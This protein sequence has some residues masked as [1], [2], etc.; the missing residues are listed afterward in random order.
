MRKFIIRKNLE[1]YRAM[2]DYIDEITINGAITVTVTEGEDKHRSLSANALQAAWYR[3][4][5]DHT[6][7]SELEV[8]KFVKREIGLPIRRHSPEAEALN[9]V[10]HK[11]NY[12]GMSIAQKD[13]VLSN[14][15][16]TSA[17]TTKEHSAFLEQMQRFYL[18]K[19]NLDLVVR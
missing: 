11:I 6:G 16:V 15:A 9:Y 1:G 2:A 8:R 10:L 4:I 7:D 12:D 13:K 5:A 17:M 19:A 14:L 3:E 18:N